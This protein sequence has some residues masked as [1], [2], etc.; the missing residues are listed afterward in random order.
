MKRS[1]NHRIVVYREKSSVNSFDWPQMI[2]WYIDAGEQMRLVLEQVDDLSIQPPQRAAEFLAEVD[3]SC[4]SG[5]ERRP[6]AVVR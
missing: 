2:D 1:R 6:S 5:L 4:V 3:R